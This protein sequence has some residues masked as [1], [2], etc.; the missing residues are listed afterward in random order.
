MIVSFTHKGLRNLF[1][2]GDVKINP[3]Y[4]E[5]LK[6]VLSRLNS[7]KDLRDMNYPGSN[8]HPLKKPPFRG[9][10][11]VNI[12]GNYRVIFRFE[13]GDAYAYEVNYL[14]TH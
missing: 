9:F 11:S 7:A 1:E 5:K 14:D 10:Y 13:N 3:N 6:R 8:L 4:A 2:K 12:S